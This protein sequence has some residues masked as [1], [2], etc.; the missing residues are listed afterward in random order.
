MHPINTPLFPCVCSRTLLLRH[1][2]RHTEIRPLAIWDL[3]N[4]VWYSSQDSSTSATETSFLSL[5]A[6]PSGEAAYKPTQPDPEGGTHF[7]HRVDRDE[8]E[9]HFP[10]PPVPSC[11]VL[12]CPVL[13][14]SATPPP[15]SR[16][17]PTLGVPINQWFAHTEPIRI[18]H[19]L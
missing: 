2:D 19:A 18:R 15:A 1:A 8:A 17:L 7:G 11:P 14:C 10:M 12:S 6:S 9:S 4:P 3:A 5:E 13:L 16:P